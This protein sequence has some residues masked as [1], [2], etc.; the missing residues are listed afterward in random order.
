MNGNG[1]AGQRAERR[2]GERSS[3]GA[4]TPAR[5]RDRRVPRAGRA[6]RRR[7]GRDGGGGGRPHGARA[8]RRARGRSRHARRRAAGRR[9]P[10]GSIRLPGALWPGQHARRAQRPGGADP[11][12]E[13]G[14]GRADGRRG[15]HP[16]HLRRRA[17]RGGEA[18]LPD[19]ARPAARR[20]AEAR[21]LRPRRPPVGRRGGARR[22]GADLAAD[23][24]RRARRRRRGRPGR[25]HGIRLPARHRFAPVDQPGPR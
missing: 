10:Q 1:D 16:R 22:Q 6:G 12:R 9:R 13:R 3:A 8:G 23:P 21:K 11:R 5:A 25:S 7:V 2:S 14:D 18:R 4:R 24:G 20:P 19:A 15:G 17:R